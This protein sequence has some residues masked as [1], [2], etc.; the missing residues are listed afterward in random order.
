[1]RDTKDAKK[2]ELAGAK[3]EEQ[4]DKPEAKRGLSRNPQND[5]LKKLF[6]QE[7]LKDKPKV[8]KVK[9]PIIATKAN[10]FD[11]IARKWHALR[12]I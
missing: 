11:Q 12:Y 2:A 9:Q 8:Q 10:Q 3:K 4:K 7:L 5:E 6:K 1:M